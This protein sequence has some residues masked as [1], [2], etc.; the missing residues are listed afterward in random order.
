VPLVRSL[1]APVDPTRAWDDISSGLPGMLTELLESD[2]YGLEQRPPGDRRG[3]Y[4]FSEADQ[5][6]YVGRTSVTARSRAG[7]LPPTTS[8]RRRYDQHTQFAT[9]PG[10][11]PL[12]NRLTREAAEAREIDIPTGWW[13]IRDDEGSEVFGLFNEAKLR[14]RA[15]ECRVVAFED[16]AKGVYSSVV[17]LY[18]H[19]QLA[20][21][22]NDFST[23]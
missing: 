23:S 22:F 21:R 11:A 15:M 9:P 8:F 16:D 18:V 12:A 19:T 17:E 4:L 3:V 6:L 1:G 14:V 13:D 2:V 10:A 20:T 5:H 7:G